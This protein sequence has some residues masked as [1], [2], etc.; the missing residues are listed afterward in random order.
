MA[1]LS[2]C[3]FCFFFLFVVGWWAICYIKLN[4]GLNHGLALSHGSDR[5]WVW[6]RRNFEEKNECDAKKW[7]CRI[8]GVCVEENGATSSFSG[9]TDSDTR[10][11]LGETH[12]KQIVFETET[13]AALVTLYIWAQKLKHKRCVLFFRQRGPK[14]CILK[15]SSDNALVEF[16]VRLFATVEF[17]PCARMWMARVLSQS[18]IADTP[19]R[20]VKLKIDV[21]DYVDCSDAARSALVRIAAEIENRRERQQLFNPSETGWSVCSMVSV[22][23]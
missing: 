21:R 1:H 15:A 22:E 3:L 8:G 11:I 2:G 19:S 6:P 7:P 5:H 18:N 14:F 13:I 23:Q 4:T 17:E 10:L 20:G 12:K 16:L 9:E